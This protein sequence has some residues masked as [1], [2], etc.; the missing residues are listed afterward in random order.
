MPTAELA[1]PYYL[2]VGGIAGYHYGYNR[3]I[4]N[5]TVR[6]TEISGPC[7]V[8]GIVGTAYNTGTV[9]ITN[10]YV[11]EDVTVTATGMNAGGIVGR[12]YLFQLENVACGAQV[13]ATGNAAGGLVG[14]IEISNDMIDSI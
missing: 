8:G 2:S 14:C 12:G 1:E 9:T 13:S 4:K 10:T 7:N 5:I 3:E 11:A 6:G